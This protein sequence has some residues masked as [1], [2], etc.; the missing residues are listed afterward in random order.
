MNACHGACLNHGFAAPT[1]PGKPYTEKELGHWYTVVP[2]RTKR[3][4]ALHFPLDLGHEEW[5]GSRLCPCGAD[6]AVPQL[7]FARVS[8][9]FL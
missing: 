8:G 9:S 1:F 3:T 7:C 4:L 2:V 5:P 6:S